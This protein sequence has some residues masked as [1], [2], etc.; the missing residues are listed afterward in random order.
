MTKFAAI[1]FTPLLLPL[2]LPFPLL[3][4]EDDLL[5]DG[6]QI[7]QEFCSVCHG[8]KGDGRSRAQGSFF[9]PPRDFTSGK[10]AEELTR[11]RMIFSVTYGRSNTAMPSWGVRLQ[12]QQVENVVDFIRNNFMQ[13]DSKAPEPTPEQLQ[14]TAEPTDVLDP[15]YMRKPMPYNLVGVPEWGK[16]FY[17]GNCAECHGTNGDGRG[18][19]AFFILPKPRDYRHP[20]ARHKLNRVR[21][22]N[23]IASG[24]HGTEMP[25]WDKVLTY[26]EIAHVSEYILQA[27]IKPD[28]LEQQTQSAPVN[29]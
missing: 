14:Q 6:S 16:T 11:T 15:G 10:S 24:S 18:P 27:F 21:L 28:E 13:L 26:Q 17:D 1:R 4:A 20:E 23:V 3:A 19:R 2:L 22:F 25:A 12:P 8:D 7:F 9:P 5:L 29:Q